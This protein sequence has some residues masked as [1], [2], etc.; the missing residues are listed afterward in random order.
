MNQFGRCFRLSLFGESH[1]PGV[2][3]VVDGVPP[4][5]PLDGAFLQADLDRRRPGASALVSQRREPDAARILSGTFE[6]RTTGAPVCVWIENQDADGRPYAAARHVP[7]P[8][9][10]DWTEHA[11]AQGFNDPRGGGHASGRLTAPLVAAGALA[12]L[13]LGPSIQVAAHLHH[14]GVHAGPQD[15]LDAKRMAEGAAASPVFTAHRALEGQFMAAIEAARRDR[16]S[17]GGVV[18]FVVEGLPVGLGE[19]FFDSVESKL[20]HLL[21]AI[22]AAKGVEFGAGFGA[23]R[24][25]GSQHNDAYTVRD[26]RVAPASNHAGGALGGRTTGEPLRGRV[27]FKPTST[28]PGRPQPSVDLRTLEPAELAMAGRH[29]PC[30]AVRAV[31]VVEACVRIALADLLLAAPGLH[32]HR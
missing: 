13:A 22:P 16:D 17:V 20:A 26:G 29:D 18:E 32:A 10:A 23:A 30:I 4:G 21:F 27:A 11:R 19:P 15:A 7:R 14:V 3:V 1:G 28:L 9:H 12:R 31:P 8:G 5:L 6:G 24:L 2:G 25:R